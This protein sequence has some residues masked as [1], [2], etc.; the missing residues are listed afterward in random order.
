MSYIFE[1]R[2][3]IIGVNPYLSVPNDILQAIFSD[4]QKSSGPIQVKGELNGLPYKQTLVKYAGEWRFYVN[5]TMLKKSP[6]RIGETCLVSVAFDP[7]SRLIEMPEGL[8]VALNQVPEASQVFETLSTSRQQEIIRYIAK[9][10]SKAAIE[11]NIERAVT[12]LLGN[13]RFVGREKP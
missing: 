2:L 5:T 3:K 12:F 9:L 4:S 13:G 1:D 10:K 8:R 6:E 7:E 11:R